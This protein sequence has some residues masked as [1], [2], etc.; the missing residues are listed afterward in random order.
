LRIDVN[1][2]VAMNQR[3]AAAIALG[4][5]LAAQALPAFDGFESVIVPNTT[6]GW[7]MTTMAFG[8]MGAIARGELR[9]IR[10]GKA[11]P[12]DLYFA[13][14]GLGGASANGLVILALICGIRRMGALTL[15]LASAA[16]A[17]ATTSLLLIRLGWDPF[18]PRIGTWLWIGSMIWLS[19]AS[20]WSLW[21]EQTPA[22]QC[23]PPG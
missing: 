19:A 5:Y 15:I 20:A 18:S 21:R 3:R 16:T 22:A 10:A 8:S 12:D 14:L 23:E 7:R 13:A 1:G 4:M 11:A 2:A 6:D 17:S 9:I